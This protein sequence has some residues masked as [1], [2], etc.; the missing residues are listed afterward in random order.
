MQF[1]AWHDHHNDKLKQLIFQNTASS[2]G[3]IPQSRT[4][5]LVCLTNYFLSARHNPQ[6]Y[7][8]SRIQKKHWKS[9]HIG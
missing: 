1:Q 6:P 4:N 5:L 7:G 9:W 3:L 8:L 2:K